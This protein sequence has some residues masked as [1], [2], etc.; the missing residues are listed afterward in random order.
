MVKSIL[1][2]YPE[3]HNFEGHPFR[4]ERNQELF[5]LRCSIDK[6]GGLVPL[7]VRKNPHGD[8]YSVFS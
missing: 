4:A 2:A 7:P 3:Q 5:E 1:A 6:E 8:G